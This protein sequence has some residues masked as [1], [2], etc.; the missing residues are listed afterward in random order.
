MGY[1]ELV[2]H[3]ASFTSG[4]DGPTR[5]HHV[6]SISESAW[7]DITLKAGYK[8]NEC[9]CQISNQPWKCIF[10]NLIYFYGL[11]RQSE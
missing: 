2:E 4:A 9:G 5:D 1:W 7:L 10:S 8:G 3:N 11:S 6:S